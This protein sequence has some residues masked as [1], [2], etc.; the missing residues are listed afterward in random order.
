[1]LS[2]LCQK[3]RDVSVVRR[4]GFA[5]TFL[6]RSMPNY[7]ET[8]ANFCVAHRPAGNYLT[9]EDVQILM[10][11]LEEIDNEAFATNDELT[12]EILAM[13][14]YGTDT[15]QGIILV[16]P[17]ENCSLCGSKMNIRAD[18]PSVVTIYDDHFGTLHATHFTK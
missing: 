5:T 16:S 12:K 1:M 15:P 18:R 13:P 9:R 7:W 8:V 4:V 3:I 11:N 6:P 10:E 2:T 14:K 17:R